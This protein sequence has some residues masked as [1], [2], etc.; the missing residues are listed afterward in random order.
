MS[1]RPTPAETRISLSQGFKASGAAGNDVVQLLQDAL[2]RQKIPVRCSALVN[3]TVGTMLSRAYQSGTAS[4]GA[5]FGTGTNGAYLE[6]MSA[7]K[8]QLPEKLDFEEMILNTECKRNW[9]MVD[10][11]QADIVLP[12][13]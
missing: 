12:I 2:N 8:K 4:V 1:L 10:Y 11:V 13:V 5:I 6:R 7:L 3:D 9:A